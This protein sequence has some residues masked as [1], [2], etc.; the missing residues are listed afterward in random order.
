MFPTQPHLAIPGSGW[1][2]DPGTAGWEGTRFSRAI[3]SARPP[4]LLPHL[5]SALSTPPPA[6]GGRGRQLCRLHAFALAAESIPTAV[7]AAP[8]RRFCGARGSCN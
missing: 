2:E 1:G 8:S 6:C 5:P 4:I 3:P 7:P